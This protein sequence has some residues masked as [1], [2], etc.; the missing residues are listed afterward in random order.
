M[1]AWYSALIRARQQHR[2]LR[3][4]SPVSTRVT[5]D[6]S[7]LLVERCCQIVLACNLE[8]TDGRLPPGE[9]ILASRPISDRVLPPDTCALVLRS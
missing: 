9:I 7:L 5:V 6:G 3:D 4:P 1:L 2:A 8:R